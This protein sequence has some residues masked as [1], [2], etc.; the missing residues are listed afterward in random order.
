MANMSP[1]GRGYTI[2]AACRQ[3]LA[4]DKSPYIMK[5]EKKKSVSFVM[6]MNITAIKY[7]FL[8]SDGKI[9]GLTSDPSFLT[10]GKLNVVKATASQLIQFC[11]LQVA[12]G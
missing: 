11:A 6:Y 7:E 5:R 2:G 3:N 9:Y 10:A 8:I 1:L 12:S 4:S